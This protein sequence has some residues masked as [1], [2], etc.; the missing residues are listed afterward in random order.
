MKILKIMSE[1]QT[2]LGQ[3]PHMNTARRLLE[4]LVAGRQ[5]TPQGLAWLVV[6]LDPWH[7]TQVL[8]V[9]GIP[10]EAIGKSIAYPVTQEYSI[11]KNRSP[12]TLPAGNWACRVSTNPILSAHTVNKGL[13]YGDIVTQTNTF[14]NL[15]PVQVNYATDGQDFEDTVVSTLPGNPSGCE[16]PLVHTKGIVRLIGLG[17]EIINTTAALN[18]QGLVSMC[19]MSQPDLEPFSSYVAMTTPANAW[20]V[21]TLT[22]VRTAPKNLSEMAL[23]PGFAQD[24]AETGYYGPVLMK[25][26]RNNSFPVSISTLLLDEDPSG[27]AVDTANPPVCYSGHIAPFVVA[28]N[29]TSFMSSRQNPLHAPSDTNVVIFTGL[30]DETTLTVRARFIIERFPS[31]SEGELLALATP[32]APYDPVALEIYSRVIR[33]LPAGVPFGENPAGEW[34]AKM[35]GSIASIVGPMVAALPHPGFKAAGLAITTGGA[36]LSS[37]AD[38]HGEKRKEKNKNQKYGP[39]KKKNRAGNVVPSNSI[40]PIKG[41]PGRAKKPLPPTP[42][43]QR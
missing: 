28:G 20:G 27:G 37:Y 34:W 16:L 41:P 31:D 3:S 26:A 39:G 17:L 13:Y 40:Q 2:N 38:S 36:A 1:V 15:M 35:L 43:R 7:D 25:P 42:R 9:E 23:Y 32:T 5:L 22:P 11:S 12:T 8:G 33:E 19:R 10:D 18:R 24:L 6:A 30:S 14:S 29:S 4:R 21:K